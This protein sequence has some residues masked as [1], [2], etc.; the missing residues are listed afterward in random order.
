MARFLFKLCLYLVLLISVSAAVSIYFNKVVMQTSIAVRKEKQL[1]A[2]FDST[3]YL[4]LGDSHVMSDINPE[5][6]PNSFNYGIGSENTIQTYYK[7]QHLLNNTPCGEHIKCVILSFDLHTLSEQRYEK[8]FNIS[9]YNR[10]MSYL[11]L[12]FETG[13]VGEFLIKQLQTY[14]WPYANQGGAI[15]QTIFNIKSERQNERLMDKGYVLHHGDLSKS[16]DST[17]IATARRRNTFLLGPEGYAIN[18]AILLKYCKKTVELCNSKGVAIVLMTYPISHHLSHTMLED[19]TI[20]LPEDRY[21]KLLSDGTDCQYLSYYDIY[22]D[23]AELFY[24]TDH[25]NEQ[26]AKLFTEKVRDDLKELGL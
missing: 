18:D 1:E 3:E 2:L 8:W 16:P 21:K 11:K 17:Q 14:F 25:L 9:F 24:D 4:F 7:L 23:Q 12:G 15:L 5:F 6:F 22:F 26:G 10:F 20:D 13:R 19:Y